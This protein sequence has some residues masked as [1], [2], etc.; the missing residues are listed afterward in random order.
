MAQFAGGLGSECCVRS[1]EALNGTARRGRSWR[2]KLNVPFG[3]GRAFGL[4]AAGGLAGPSAVRLSACRV[5]Q[6]AAR[7]LRLNSLMARIIGVNLIGLT[8]SRRRPCAD[9]PVPDLADR[10]QTRQ[11]AGAGRDHRPLPRLQRSLGERPHPARSIR[12]ST[13]SRAPRSRSTSSGRASRPAIPDPAGKS[14]PD[15]HHIVGQTNTRA[16]VY[17]DDG[18][19]I[20]D[21]DY[22]EILTRDDLPP[23]GTQPRIRIEGFW[24]KVAKLL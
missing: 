3:L 23:P 10:R 5:D 4:A 9:Q 16:R 18:T 12:A 22:L 1:T 14:R 15:H 2:S 17:S 24:N 20:S 19:L 8:D 6:A 11:P 7:K 13:S 21:S